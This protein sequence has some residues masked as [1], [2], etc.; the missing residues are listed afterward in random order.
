LIAINA[1]VITEV[2]RVGM[3]SFSGSTGAG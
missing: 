1:I 2:V 3:L